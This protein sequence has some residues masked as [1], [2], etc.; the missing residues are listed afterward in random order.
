M[1]KRANSHIKAAVNQAGQ[2]V[3]ES[4]TDELLAFGALA[5]VICFA[6]EPKTFLRTGQPVVPWGLD[7]RG[8]RAS[9]FIKQFAVFVAAGRTCFGGGRYLD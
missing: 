3:G 8:L 9:I 1:G 2:S 6:W 4:K 5:D 7:Q